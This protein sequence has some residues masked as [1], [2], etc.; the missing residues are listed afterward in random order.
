MADQMPAD[1]L[2]ADKIKAILDTLQV[3]QT[4]EN[5]AQLGVYLQAYSVFLDRN[6]R[7]NAAWRIAGVPGLLVDIRKKVERL[8]NEF[9]LSE[10]RPPDVDSAID[11]INYL[12]FFIQA[13]GEERNGHSVGSWSWPNQQRPEVGGSLPDHG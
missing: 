2:R 9:M 13:I 10:R 3:E 5:A 6:Q 1:L 8:W 12:A 7:H 11:A 4:A